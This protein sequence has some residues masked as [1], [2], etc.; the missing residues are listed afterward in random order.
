MEQDIHNKIQQYIDGT[1]PIDQRPLFE[2]E[3]GNDATLM[4]DYQLILDIESELGNKDLE[5]F[6]MNLETVAQ[7]YNQSEKVEKKTGR[8]FSL[9]RRALS[10]AATFAILAAAFVWFN[11]YGSSN[12]LDN[13][14]AQYDFEEIYSEGLRSDSDS[15]TQ[16]KSNTQNMILLIE[17]EKY[18][19]A[20]DFASNIAANNRIN[21]LHAHALLSKAKNENNKNYFK[22]SLNLI[23]P[24]LNS[25]VTEIK[26]E[27]EWIALLSYSTMPEK[28]ND[29]NKLIQNISKN[30]DHRFY[31][32]VNKILKSTKK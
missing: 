21:L 10:I 3:L 14:L 24:L 32:K 22:S 25:D 18:Q 28:Q 12:G 19:E 15:Q 1:M 5:A 13:S 30:T 16:P 20:I 8:V 26:E 2:Q 9:P 7:N 17:Q 29:Y 6:K 31:G 23:T 11:R 4:Q 27:A